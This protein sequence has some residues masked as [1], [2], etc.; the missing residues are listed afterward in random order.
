VLVLLTAAL[1][2]TPDAMGQALTSEQ[3]QFVERIEVV[4]RRVYLDVL[5]E[6]RRPAAELTPEMLTVLEDGVVRP[7]LEVHPRSLSD[8]GTGATP[9]PAATV[10]RPTAAPPPQRFVLLA[11]DPTTLGRRAWKAAIAELGE[12]A[13]SLVAA[14]P[15]DVVVLT[16]PPR[17]F[18]AASREAAAVRA[19]LA[20][21][22]RSVQPLDQFYTGRARFIREVQ[23]IFDTRRGMVGGARDPF[24]AAQQDIDE[25]NQALAAARELAGDEERMLRV[26]LG[27]LEGA[28]AGG[29]RPLIAVWAAQGDPD[30][31]AFARQLLA[32][33]AGDVEMSTLSGSPLGVIPVLEAI[34]RRWAA[35]GVTV[36][37]WSQEGEALLAVSDTGT[38][39]E[40][41]GH[42]R[43]SLGEQPLALAGAV[44]EDTGGELVRQAA[45][46]TSAMATVGG[47]FELVYQSDN[48]APGWRDLRITVD[49]PGWTV[50][51]SPRMYV[52]GPARIAAAGA[53]P[54]LAVELTATSRPAE[55]PGRELVTLPILVDLEP[56]RA[57]L[58]ADAETRI[59]F[60]VFATLPGGATVTREV[61]VLLHGVPAEGRLRY[62]TSLLVPRGTS[63]YAVQVREAVTGAYGAA[64]PVEA[65]SGEW[66]TTPAAPGPL[67]SPT[68]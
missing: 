9:A 45:E 32:G 8:A 67:A 22:G 63:S 13:E 57:A 52:A 36:V 56:L 6:S 40:L 23:D 20:E 30:T 41:P 38:R 18:L 11:L 51:T 27:R 64:G 39:H 42:P 66:I 3:S 47:R 53:P 48:A 34:W 62:E 4:A 1:T 43:F 19:A 65:V 25:V 54:V 12:A 37:S 59:V 44:A 10:R 31:L 33:R 14:G 46:I 17:R 49:R 24:R 21:I 55:Q 15:V 7:I 28:L 5:D 68:R 26:S 60:R 16:A 35:D 2:A 50:R 61:E 29:G 58:A